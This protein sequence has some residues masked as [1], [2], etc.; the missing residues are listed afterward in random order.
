VGQF[1]AW[2]KSLRFSL[3][4]ACSPFGLDFNSSLATRGV[5]KKAAPRPVFRALAQSPLHRV[6]VNVVELLYKLRMIANVEVVVALPPEMLGVPDQPPC[7]S[8]LQ[9]LGERRLRWGSSLGLADQKVNVLGHDDVS[10]DAKAEA[11][12]HALKGVLKDV[13]ARVVRE[14]GTAVIRR[15]GHEMALPGM[16]IT[17]KAPRHEVSVAC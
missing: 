15:E 1:D 3:A 17:R 5:M 6:A 4:L 9:R 10:V 12:A 8:F 2:A 13:S 16:V 14:Q 7:H 11:A